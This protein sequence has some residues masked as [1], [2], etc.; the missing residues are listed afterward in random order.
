MISEGGRQ[1]LLQ[2]IYYNKSTQL[3]RENLLF[4]KGYVLANLLASWLDLNWD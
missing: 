2:C 1:L 3:C 4:G